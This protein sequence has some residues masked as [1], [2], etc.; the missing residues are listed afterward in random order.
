MGLRWHA[1]EDTL[2]E[3]DGFWILWGRYVNGKRGMVF[4]C[5]TFLFSFCC[6]RSYGVG[7]CGYSAW[8]SCV[9]VGD[10]SGLGGSSWLPNSAY[11]RDSSGKKAMSLSCGIWREG[12]WLVLARLDVGLAGIC[13]MSWFGLVVLRALRFRVGGWLGEI[14]YF[15]FSL[16]S[17]C[18]VA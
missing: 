6:F 10:N 14:F 9:L 17:L 4:C 15:V 13:W 12:F 8:R 11:G 5:I 2:R 1:G 7:A 3:E 18:I 16:A